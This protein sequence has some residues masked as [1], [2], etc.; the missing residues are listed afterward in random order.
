MDKFKS[1]AKGGWHPEKSRANSGSS[2]GGQSDSK[3]GQVKGWVGKA[4]GKDVHAESARE[5]QSAPLSSLKDPASF[6]PPPKRVNYNAVPASSGTRPSTVAS[7]RTEE[8]EEAED[9][10]PAPGPYRRDTTGLSTAH[11]PKPPAFRPG[12]ASPTT[13]GSAPKPKPSLPPRLPP[14]Q[15]SNPHEFSAAPPPTYNEATQQETASHG[16]LNQGALG[17]LGQAGV[18]VPGFGIGRTAS[19]PVPPRANPSPPVPPRAKSSSSTT[20]PPPVASGHGSQMNEL[21]NRFAKLTGPK[22]RTPA[23]APPPTTGTSWADKQAA[24]RT[25]SNLRN[26]PSKVSASDLKGAASTANNF[27]QRHGDQVASGWKSANSLNQKYGIMG[28]MNSLGSSSGAAA[29]P[30]VQS[31]TQIQGSQGGGLGKKAPPPPPPKKKE[32]GNG[33]GEAPPIPLSSKPKF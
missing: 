19:P 2:A 4:Q 24:L 1:V 14:R 30:P 13:T 17:R 32:L 27:Q 15:N 29:P 11:L 10:R 21:Q 23:P 12:T 20:V 6:A 3:L 9:N 8:Q 18:S 26:D 16:G 28:K 7:S 25:A 31:P 33:S 22:S 5:H